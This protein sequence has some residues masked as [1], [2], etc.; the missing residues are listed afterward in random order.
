MCVYI[1]E[2]EPGYSCGSLK[3]EHNTGHYLLTWRSTS[4]GTL[5]LVGNIQTAR[6]H[7]QSQVLHDTP[8]MSLI[9]SGI[10]NHGEDV[11]I[12]FSIEHKSTVR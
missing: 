7:T 12:A 1:N 3:W 5:H 10:W 9:K 4:G 2:I 6:L 8:Q 11:T